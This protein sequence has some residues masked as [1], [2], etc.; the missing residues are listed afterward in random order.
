MAQRRKDTTPTR[1]GDIPPPFAAMIGSA[2]VT[3]LPR[4]GPPPRI[5]RHQLNRGSFRE[6][7]TARWLAE[8]MERTRVMT[9]TF[10]EKIQM[11]AGAKYDNNGNW[12]QGDTK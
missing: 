7:Q 10:T 5:R 11:E 1:S 8:R 9:A 3:S 12:N 4:A 6:A 2:Q